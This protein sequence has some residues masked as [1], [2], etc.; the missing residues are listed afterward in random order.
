MLIFFISEIPY[1]VILYTGNGRG[2]VLT[3]FVSQLLTF[4][5]DQGKSGEFELRKK[6][7]NFENG[8]VDKF[9]LSITDR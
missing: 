5:G 9:I 3:Y 1:E 6:T 8:K 4:Y 7:D 2:L